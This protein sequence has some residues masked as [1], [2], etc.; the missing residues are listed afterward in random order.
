MAT[1]TE[2]NR[3]VV[4]RYLEVYS[5]G[6]METLDETIAEDY[7]GHAIP[8][9]MPQ[10]PEGEKQLIGM[11]RSGIPD[12]QVTFE[13]QFATGDKVVTRW[14]GRGTH[15]GNLFGIPATGKQ[16]NLEGISIHRLAGGKVVESW[17][18]FNLLNVMQQIGVVPG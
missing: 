14:T 2:A 4:H 5:N 12:L 7:V 17:V 11:Y 13:D 8:P 16:V 1:E 9:G 6:R 10:G 15:G 18:Q 3:E